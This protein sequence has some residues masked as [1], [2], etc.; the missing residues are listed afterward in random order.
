MVDLNILGN[1]YDTL[2]GF[3]MIIDNDYLKCISQWPNEMQTLA[4][5]TM[6]RYYLSLITTF[7][8]F[9]KILSGLGINELLYFLIV[10]LNFFWEKEVQDKKD[11][12]GILSR[13]LELIC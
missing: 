6:L 12:D 5:L 3:R 2:L 11:F 8:C 4:I 10:L 7:R 9:Y 1:S 13:I